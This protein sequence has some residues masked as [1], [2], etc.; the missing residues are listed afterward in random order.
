MDTLTNSGIQPYT[1]EQTIELMET[2]DKIVQPYV[3]LHY[4]LIFVA[5]ACFTIGVYKKNS[6]KRMS[7]VIHKHK[8]FK[9]A[10]CGKTT[11]EI[12]GDNYMT[13]SFQDKD[14]TCKDCLEKIKEMSEAKNN[15]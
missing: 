2:I 10:L 9:V 12:I 6:E 5:F 11:M 7:E 3:V 8:E 4:L 14:V 13:F 15:V 1:H